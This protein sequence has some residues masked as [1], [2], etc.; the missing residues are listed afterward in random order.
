MLKEDCQLKILYP[1]KYCSGMRVKYILRC[2]KTKLIGDHFKEIA[3]E[4]IPKG[5]REQ[6]EC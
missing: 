5:N 2:R 3:K 4:M 1:V 6:W